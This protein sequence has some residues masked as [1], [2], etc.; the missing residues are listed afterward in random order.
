MGSSLTNRIYLDFLQVRQKNS[1]DAKARNSMAA[2][3]EDAGAYD[4]A[5][6]LR[7]ENGFT[8]EEGFNHT[9]FHLKRKSPA[10]L[11]LV[12]SMAERIRQSPGVSIEEKI[13]SF[14]NNMKSSDYEY[15]FQRF[16]LLYYADLSK[17]EREYLR[18]FS[19]SG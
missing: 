5:Y 4:E 8:L 9:L 15:F 14:L 19:I 10:V 11:E 2:S 17:G 7:K 16:P 3:L 1:C 6:L 18:R 12:M 13:S